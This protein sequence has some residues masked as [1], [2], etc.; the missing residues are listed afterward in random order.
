MDGYDLA[1]EIRRLEQTAGSRTPILAITASDF[2]LDEGKARSAGLDG[3]MLKPLDPEVLA[4][5]LADIFRARAE[6]ELP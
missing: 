5:K 4:R 6:A 3:Y 1:A 2:D